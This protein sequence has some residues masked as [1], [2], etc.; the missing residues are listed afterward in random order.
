MNSLF[1][2]ANV[3]FALLGFVVAY[4]LY[5]LF[6]GAEAGFWTI[7]LGFVVVL[8]AMFGALRTFTRL[9]TYVESDQV[10]INALDQDGFE[11][12]FREFWQNT[13]EVVRF[14][15]ALANDFLSWVIRK[16]LFGHGQVP[17]SELC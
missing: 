4:V 2:C 15:D 5:G 11:G 10:I 12:H 13:Q 7:I 1:K 16:V 17:G 3:L 8:T 6:G 14:V 9:A